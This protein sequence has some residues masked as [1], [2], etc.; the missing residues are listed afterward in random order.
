VV[1]AL[2]EDTVSPGEILDLKPSQQR[3]LEILR[4]DLETLTDRQVEYHFANGSYSGN[5]LALGYAPTDRVNV[6]LIATPTGWTAVA[7]HEDH[8]A[9]L[10][11]A[12]YGGAATPPRAPVRPIEPGVVVCSG[13]SA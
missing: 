13:D 12:V 9:T 3:I 6:S 11:C 5:T 1:W 4:S 10:G 8:P 7:T 2:P